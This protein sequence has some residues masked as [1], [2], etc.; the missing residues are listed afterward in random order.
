LFFVVTVGA[1]YRS[2][3]PRSVKGLGA[4]VPLERPQRE[5]IRAQSFGLRKQYRADA[6]PLMAGPRIEVVQMM[7]MQC[8]VC[9]ASW[10]FRKD[11]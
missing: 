2:E 1:A 3:S 8:E 9:G 5:P 11:S 4:G 10:A 7:I 6:T